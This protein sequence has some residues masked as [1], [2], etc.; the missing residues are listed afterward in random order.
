MLVRR[1]YYHIAFLL[2]RAGSGGMALPAAR[3]IR[4]SKDLWNERRQIYEHKRTYQPGCTM[5]FLR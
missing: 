5:Y 3:A 1:S 2:C 4:T